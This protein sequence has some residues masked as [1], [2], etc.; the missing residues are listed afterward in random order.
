MTEISRNDV[1][2]AYRQYFPL[3]RSK[4]NRMLRD[5]A[6]AQ[7]LAQEVFTRFWRERASIADPSAA[8]AWLYRTAT[9]LAVDRLRSRRTIPMADDA[10][11]SLAGGGGN[12]EGES[13]ARRTLDDLFAALPA[14][15]LQ[16]A[17]LA[18]VDGLTQ[19]EI[20]EV[21]GTSERT[22]RRLLVKFEEHLARFHRK[23]G[24]A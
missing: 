16:A 3:I 19:P 9:N 24:E 17:L 22:V 20:A 21:M 4:C 7:D 10:L 2:A 5:G 23:R 15:A 1:E 8:T 13:H 12:P 6:E 14:D 18:R 11:A